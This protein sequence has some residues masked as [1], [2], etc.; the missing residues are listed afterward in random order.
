[1][2]LSA[3]LHP[4][5]LRSFCEYKPISQFHC[6]CWNSL[7]A[8]AAHS[9]QQAS[10]APKCSP[11]MQHSRG[12]RLRGV[13]SQPSPLSRAHP[14]TSCHSPPRASTRT[15]PAA[16]ALSATMP[17]LSSPSPRQRQISPRQSVPHLRPVARRKSRSS[18]S[19]IRSPFLLSIIPH[20]SP[21]ALSLPRPQ[22]T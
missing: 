11:G 12:R 1:M 18:C 14:L 17:H 9:P 7:S 16:A 4:A 15:R 13:P 8:S 20:P 2:P 5:P 10:P 3:P 21:K 22:H 19:M 6:G